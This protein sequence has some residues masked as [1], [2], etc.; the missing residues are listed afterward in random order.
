MGD[1]GS[2][3]ISEMDEASKAFAATFHYTIEHTMGMV[4]I[5]DGS[6]S[7]SLAKDARTNGTGRVTANLDPAIFPAG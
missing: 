5:V 7:L 1:R 6:L 4:E 3:D 2:I